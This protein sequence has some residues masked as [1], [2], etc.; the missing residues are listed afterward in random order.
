MN[1]IS[2]VRDFS[3]NLGFRHAACEL[4]EKIE[5]LPQEKV[6]ID[7]DKVRFISRAFAHEYLTRKKTSSKHIEEISVPEVVEKMFYAVMCQK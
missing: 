1:S 6:V 2:L 4:F 3:E 7:F 5:A